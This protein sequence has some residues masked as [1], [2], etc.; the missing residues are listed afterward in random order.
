MRKHNKVHHSKR[1]SGRAMVA[2]IPGSGW[3]VTDLCQT[4]HAIVNNK[5][6]Q[7]HA[8]NLLQRMMLRAGVR[9]PSNTTAFA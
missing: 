3:R 7:F 1:S 2:W 9:S 5:S 6:W 8:N 4:T